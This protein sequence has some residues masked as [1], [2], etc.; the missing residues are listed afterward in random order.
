MFHN[1]KPRLARLFLAK[2][3]SH[4]LPPE[5]FSAQWYLQQYPDVAVAGMNPWQHY[6]RFGKEE[7]RLPAP[8]RALGLGHALWRGAHDVML[9][10]LE[11][12]LKASD[13]TSY[14]QQLARW[15]L[16][17]WYAWQQNWERVVA[18]L[19]PAHTLPS[20]SE[21]PLGPLLLRL[22]ALCRLI[23]QAPENP[24]QG[25]SAM[26]QRTVEQLELGG[27]AHTD[28]VLAK[29]N[30]QLVLAGVQG[31]QRRLQ[32]L[33]G[34]FA[35][36]FSERLRLQDGS[37][38]LTLNNL[39]TTKAD[40]SAFNTQQKGSQL[41]LVSVIVPVYNAANTL[42]A[43]LRS[44]YAQSW[45]KVELLLVD[46]ASTDNSAEVIKAFQVE[47]PS[48]I[49]Q[50]LI[51]HDKNRGAYASRNT[52]LAVAKGDFITVHDSDDWSHPQKLEQQA[53]VLLGHDP[54][55]QKAQSSPEKPLACLSYWVRV[56][57]E[58]LFHRWRL[59][60]YGWVYPNISSLMF[61]REVFAQIGFWDLVRVNADTEYRER[62]EAAFGKQAVVEVL[63]GVPLSFG[64]ADAGSLSQRAATHLVTQFSGVRNDYMQAARAWHAC[65]QGSSGLYLVQNPA[66]RPFVAPAAMVRGVD[67][68]AG[69]APGQGAPKDLARVSGW[70]DSGWYLQRYIG[71]Q[72]DR[73]EPFEH[74]WHA[75]LS[76][77]YDPGP[78]FSTSGYLRVCPQAA[79]SDNPLAHYLEAPNPAMALPV[80]QG[81]KHR[82]GRPTIM[83]CGHQAGPTL[84]G[85]ERSLLDLLDALDQLDCNVLVT[86]P[87]ALNAGYEQHILSRCAALAVLPY[88]WWQQGHQP[89]KATVNHFSRLI[90]QFGVAAVHANTLVLDEPLRAARQNGVPAFIHVRELPAA[91]PALCELLGSDAA[92]IFE[93]AAGLAGVLIANSRHTQ[94]KIQQV[95]HTSPLQA[96]PTY[97]VPNTVAMEPL[98]AIPELLG[99]ACGPLRVGMLSSNLLKKGLADVELLAE[100][101]QQTG[102]E[103]E[104][105]VIGP[106]TD[107]LRALLARQAAGAVPANITYHGYVS[108]P[109]AVLASLGAVINLSHFEESFGRTVLEAMAAARPVVAYDWGALAELIVPGKTGF[110][111]PL[112]DIKSIARY[113]N[114]LAASAPRCR[115][116]GRAGRERAQRQFGTAAMG[117]AL[118]KAYAQG[119]LMLE[120]A[121]EGR[122]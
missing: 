79:A 30:A 87:E 110:L 82:A 84:F 90:K 2:A 122:L 73:I 120:L 68:D 103:V 101:L 16:A 106:E 94:D 53:Q 77:R 47:C 81:L 59:D 19:E 49:Q 115:D 108:E 69:V 42:P 5:W 63:P 78:N 44:L 114:K 102:A 93:H 80:W 10:A 58:L 88:G 28:I 43:V 26:L 65:A 35:Q 92:G 37:R 51:Q 107:A 18:I 117:L 24:A 56:T 118:S 66:L 45:P 20:L 85:A 41:P 112:G 14:E 11:A 55:K 27:K 105:V 13:A 38:P 70:F 36:H 98:L 48:H 119:G 3:P 39:V 97:V 100:I 113:L 50:R 4:D 57:D 61:R 31:D 54:S 86:L 34:L 8:N 121:P 111:A 9:P 12:L 95:L 29:A 23:R 6:S 96:V 99:A 25:W 1:L 22:E 116:L 104:L 91:D 33:N 109:A 62:I 74:F 32:L 46:D 15:E 76:Q 72:R 64:L 83:L 21:N 75:A 52:A 71:L 40:Q 89:V 7:G 67:S 60:E 17:R